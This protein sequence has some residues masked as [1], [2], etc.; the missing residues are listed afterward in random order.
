LPDK[1]QR[2]EN[3]HKL[4]TKELEKAMPGP[5]AQEEVADPIVHAHFFSCRNG[6]D[7]FAT[8]AWQNVVNAETGDFIEERPLSAPLKDGEKCE[9]ITFFGWVRGADFEA[10]PWSLN[11]FLETNERVAPRGRGLLFVERDMHWTPA[12]LSLVKQQRHIA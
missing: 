9:D 2:K 11:E 5:R 6:W 12:P 4:I 1:E 7:W 10:G 8:E 3:M